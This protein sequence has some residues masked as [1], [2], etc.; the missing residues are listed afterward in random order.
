M[1]AWRRFLHHLAA[2]RPT[3]IITAELDPLDPTSPQSPLFE[4]SHLLTIRLPF[5]GET[6]VYLHHYLRSD[7][8]RGP[9]DHPWPW[10][11]AIP[12]AGGYDEQRAAALTATGVPVLR[13]FRRRPFVPYTLAGRDFHRVVCRQARDGSTTTSWSLFIHGPNTKGWGFLRTEPARDGLALGYRGVYVPHVEPDGSHTSW[14]RT[15]PKGRFLHRAQ[16]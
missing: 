7:P 10:M 3:R 8:D 5:I 11:L 12:L 2:R 6:T 9:H 4:R 1:T 16:P 15:A 14:W 13:M